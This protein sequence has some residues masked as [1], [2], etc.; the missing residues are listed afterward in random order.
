MD[1]VNASAAVHVFGEGRARGGTVALARVKAVRN[2]GMFAF[3]SGGTSAPDQRP[4]V[5]I[6]GGG[7]LT[8]MVSHVDFRPLDFMLHLV[9]HCV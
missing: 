7:T 4:P 2:V 1:P 8:H 9:V 6:S 3:Y 5:W